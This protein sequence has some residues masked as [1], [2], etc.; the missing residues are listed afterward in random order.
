[1]RPNFEKM[2]NQELRDYAIANRGNEDIDDVLD[3]LYSRRSPDSEAIWFHP[4]NNQEEEQEQLE[5]F[6][7]IIE[8]KV[9]KKDTHN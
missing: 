8:G 9:T 4:P 3:V 6:K 1:M 7:Q 5:L 2:T